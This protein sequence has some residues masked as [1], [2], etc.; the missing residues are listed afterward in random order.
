MNTQ[1]VTKM[2][3]LAVAPKIVSK[4]KL[5]WVLIA[6]GTYYGLKYL[7]RKGLLPSAADSVLSKVDTVIDDAKAG[8]GFHS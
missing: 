1:D 8:F 4:G 7:S 6:A 5:K 3:A 2:A